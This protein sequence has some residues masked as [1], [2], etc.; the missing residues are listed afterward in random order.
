[1]KKNT[2]K[3]T[4]VAVMTAMAIIVT[5]FIRFP[6]TSLQFLKYD[7]KDIIISSMGFLFGPIYVILSSV[8]E[9]FIEMITFSETGYI[10]FIMNVIAT[11]TFSGTAA[12]IYKKN[13]TLKGAIIS[14]FCATLALTGIMILWNYIITPYY[15][16]VPR[17]AVVK[18]L[19]MIAVFNLAK[20]GINS[21]FT[22]IVYKPLSKAVHSS[23]IL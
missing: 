11:V 19:P 22:L 5:A 1:M 3:L 18:L 16:G 13:K 23:G 10:G 15:M 8:V 4:V 6:I 2:Q 17:D 7:P 21:I 12:L 14:L 20:G 9:A